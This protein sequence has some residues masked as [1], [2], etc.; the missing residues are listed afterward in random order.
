MDTA[1]PLDHGPAV[2]FCPG[3]RPDRYAKALAAADAVILDLED[4]VGPDDKDAARDAVVAALAELDRTRVIVR[5]NAP[6]TAAHDGDVAALAAHPGLTL[7]LP[8]ATSAAAV[9]ALA[10][11]P[12]IALCETA[13]GVLQA[14]AI[15]RA[16]NCTALMWGSEDLLADLGGRTGRTAGGG[17]GPALT[18]ARTRV[19]YAARAAGAVPVD[20]VLTDIADTDRLLADA[21]DAANA[22]FAAKVCIHPSQVEVVRRGFRPTDAEVE[23]A[24]ALLAEAQH[25][26]G[27]FRHDGEMVDAPVLARARAT[28]ARAGR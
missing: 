14:P 16:A 11:H 8:M 23:H 2:L 28:V 25:H 18:E 20:T 6:G 10:P 22:G 15:A 21:T 3:N 9:E 5:I 17:Y 19:L 12:V 26:P 13:H 27:V 7:M 4:A 24:R 1:Q